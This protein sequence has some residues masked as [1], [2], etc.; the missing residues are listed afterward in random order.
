MAEGIHPVRE[1]IRSAAGIE[2]YFWSSRLTNNAEGQ[3]LLKVLQGRCSGVE[4]SDAVMAKIAETD[5]PQGIIATV[6]IPP[7][8]F[9]DLAGLSLGLIVDGLQDPGNIGTIIRMAWAENVDGLFF[10]PGTADPYQGKVVR[11]S[12]GGIFF[13]KVYRGVEREIICSQAKQAGVRIV[14]GDPEAAP[15]IFEENFLTPTLFLVGNEGNGIR[16]GWEDFSIQRVRIPQ[17]GRAESLNV[18]V[19]A[20][21]MVYEAVRQRYNQGTG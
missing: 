20:G 17:P 19:A 5:N 9:P 21:I 2:H 7:N 14:A 13:Q 1:A 10:T 16:S 6:R 18:A 4:V 8:P 11:A 15:L 12:M 3:E